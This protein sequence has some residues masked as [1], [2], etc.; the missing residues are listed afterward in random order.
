MALQKP[1]MGNTKAKV[2]LFMITKHAKTAF[3]LTQLKF[4][5]NVF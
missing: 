4:I 3:P 5:G 2:L 1:D